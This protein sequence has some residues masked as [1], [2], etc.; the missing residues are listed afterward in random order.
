[1]ALIKLAK[2]GDTPLAQRAAKDLQRVFDDAINLLKKF[3]P[4]QSRTFMEQ[5]KATWTQY[6]GGTVQKFNDLHNELTIIM[7]NRAF[8]LSMEEKNRMTPPTIDE[9]KEG[10]RQELDHVV[11]E[12]KRVGEEKGQ[13]LEQLDG[14]SS[15]SKRQVVILDSSI[16]RVET[17][18]VLGSGA[19]GVVRAGMLYGST[20]VAV[21]EIEHCSGD[22]AQML[23]QE[24]ERTMRVSHPNVVK[25]FGLLCS[26]DSKIPSGIVME[27]LGNDLE[28]VIA[29]ES[30]QAAQRM[31]Y[32]NDLIAGMAHVHASGLIHFDLKLKNVLRTEDKHR[33]KII[34]FGISLGTRSVIFGNTE[35]LRGTPQY[36]A[37]EQF[38]A[39]YGECG[40]KCDVYAFGVLLYELW[41]GKKVWDGFRD[42]QVRESVIAGRPP[43]N[44]EQMML[45]GIPEPIAKLID[46]CWRSKPENRPTFRQMQ[47]IR[48]VDAFWR[49][50][51]ERWP[52]F[53]QP[54]Q[55]LP[56]SP[57]SAALPSL[58]SSIE[59]L[60]LSSEQL[61]QVLRGHKIHKDTL[62]W[63]TER[64]YNG[65]DFLLSGYK[66]VEAMRKD[67]RDELY[68]D[69]FEKFYQKII[70]NWPPYH[71]GI[72]RTQV[73]TEEAAMC[74]A[75]FVER[76]NAE[77]LAVLEEESVAIREFRNL[78]NLGAQ[79]VLSAQEEKKRAEREVNQT[80]QRN[81]VE[82]ERATGLQL[83][84]VTQ[85]ESEHRAQLINEQAQLRQGFQLP[86][87]I[88]VAPAVVRERI[89][90]TQ[91]ATRVAPLTAGLL[92]PGDWYNG[93][94][95]AQNVSALEWELGRKNS[96]RMTYKEAQAYAASRAAEGWRLPTIWE[97]FG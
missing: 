3:Q 43:A 63:I 32:T 13:R 12:V 49:S 17:D 31:A 5:I 48:E 11:L 56:S 67:Q 9:I 94:R 65:A 1:M 38:D 28:K 30:L 50:T 55:V 45:S 79:R 25:V 52:L 18:A 2:E 42:A 88:K 86:K 36:M 74:D 6:S 39:R 75:L 69:A 33:V 77:R 16:V 87:P 85:Q 78:L 70:V 4:D 14:S 97:L 95:E 23:Q 37:P 62:N 72:H 35:A 29:S 24:V 91:I 53:L 96:K 8:A 64:D 60:S 7:N 19:F 61:C 51:P 73:M 92:G 40:T 21:K 83:F 54:Q 76:E 47:G 27:R 93:P 58:P 66:M 90:K 15:G 59:F 20:L 22:V 34:D 68:I 44:I 84:A 71:E 82:R 81:E 57:V 10:V 46:V 26:K 80:S 41:S 89:A